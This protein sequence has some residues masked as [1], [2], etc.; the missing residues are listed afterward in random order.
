MKTPRGY[1]GRRIQQTGGSTFAVSLPKAW[2]RAN[3]LTRGALVYFLPREDGSL[4]VYTEEVPKLEKVRRVCLVTNKTPPDHIFRRLVSVYI[5]GA[6]LV[7]V[8]T[9]ERMDPSTREVV[10][11]FVQ[12][13]I[14]PEILEETPTGVV[15]QD[16]VSSNPMPLP[17]VLRRMH[18]MAREM[19][20]D[21]MTGF[22]GQDA[23]I[24]RDVADRDW[25]IDRLHWFVNKTV[26]MAL[27]DPRL[28]PTL[29]ITLPDCLTYDLASK[30]LERIADHA[31][32]I[33]R[34]T[35]MVSDVRLPATQVEQLAKL[36]EEALV[37]LDSAVETIF[38]GDIDKANEVIDGVGKTL[39][40]RGPELEQIFAKKGRVAV[41]LAYV[42][43]SLERTALYAADLAEIALNHA[44]NSERPP[45][46]SPEGSRFTEG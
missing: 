45:P 29:S 46:P 31:V 23:S 11:K 12:Q 25:E 6:P 2:V 3:N 40:S 19:Q 13:V 26:V 17:S 44:V 42:L 7:E 10:R 14:G 27:K 5:S 32:R 16:M 8:R 35:T 4:S 41:A 37:F 33:S 39:I 36:S 30:T 18:L 38:T 15:L 24:A 1:E 22:R 21:A 20:S 43:E 34:V 9:K 28:L